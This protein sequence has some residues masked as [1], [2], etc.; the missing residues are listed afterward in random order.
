[1]MG[2]IGMGNNPMVGASVAVA[3]AV[4]HAYF[5]FENTVA[6]RHGENHTTQRH[7]NTEKSDVFVPFD[8]HL[9]CRNKYYF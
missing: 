7:K 5:D 3:V 9:Y 8:S 1:M 6:L 4:S 2:L